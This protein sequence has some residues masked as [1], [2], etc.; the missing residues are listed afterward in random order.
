MTALTRTTASY[1]LLAVSAGMAGGYW[2]HAHLYQ[3]IQVTLA[4]GAFTGRLMENTA[5]LAQL[6]RGNTSC[7]MA[8]LASRVR[9][10]LDQ[11]SFYR[12]YAAGDPRHVD[13]HIKAIDG[14]K[15]LAAE[16]LSSLGAAETPANKSTCR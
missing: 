1:L 9:T 5:D 4:V 15:E 16:V 8:E 7:V 10:D 12:T 6:K 11:V 14:A 13:D 3:P 2:L